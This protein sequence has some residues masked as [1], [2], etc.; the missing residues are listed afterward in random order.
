[1]FNSVVFIFFVALAAL[2]ALVLFY[3]AVAGR[4]NNPGGK[5][6]WVFFIIG[7]VGMVIV[8]AFLLTPPG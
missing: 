4:E 6:L 8:K 1:V 5:T 2:S 7:L 3:R